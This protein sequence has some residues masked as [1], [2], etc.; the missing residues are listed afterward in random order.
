MTRHNKMLLSFLL[1]F[2]LSFQGLLPIFAQEAFGEG[3]SLTENPM[4]SSLTLE[5]DELEEGL[6]FTENSTEESSLALE[7][8]EALPKE[9]DEL[10]DE[11]IALDENTPLGKTGFFSASLAVTNLFESL[12]EKVLN[13]SSGDT[14]TLEPGEY[15]FTENLVVDKPLTFVSEGDVTFKRSP[16]LTGEMISITPIG[17]LTLNKGDGEFVFD[18]EGRAVNTSAYF[19][20]AEGN[21]EI[22]GAIFQN[23][24]AR[25]GSRYA[26][27]K[28][29]GA[30]LVFNQGKIHSNDYS[31]ANTAYSSGGIFLERG[32]SME[33]NGGEISANQASNYLIH[34]SMLWSDSPGAGAIYVHS[35]ASFVMNAGLIKSNK[36]WAGG[37]LIG[38]SS[39]YTYKR[40]ATTESSLIESPLATAVFNGGTIEG[41]EAVGGA[42]SG[43]GNVDITL[44]EASSVLIQ[45]NHS[46][47]GGG[48]FI[49]DWAV[50]G[51]GL[52][53]EIAKLPIE[54]WSR[55]YQGRFFMAGG[56][57]INNTAINCG[58]G[59][60]VSTNGAQIVGGEILNNRAG[61]QGG[62]IYVTTVPYT[63]KLENVYI[64]SNSA[65]YGTTT[66]IDGIPLYN[67]SGGGV[68]FCPTGSA[69]FH[70]ENGAALVDNTAAR[71]GDDFWSSRKVQKQGQS[72][73]V[74]L[75]DRLLGGTKALYYTDKRGARYTE[76]SGEAPQ[77]I[78]EV[79]TDLS[80]KS[81][82]DEGKAITKALSTLHIIGNRASKGGG[83][84]S[85]GNIIFG[86]EGPLKNIRLKKVWAEG[87][88][89]EAVT[90]ELRA[91][92]NGLDYLIEAVQLDASNGF[93]ATIKD[94]PQTIGAHPLEEVVY[95]KELQNANYSATI[96]P[97][98]EST[99]HD[100]SLNLSLNRPEFS[101]YENIHAVYE[102][103]T[104]IAIKLHRAGKEPIIK[105]MSMDKSTFTWQGR[106]N[107]EGL[108]VGSERVE[109]DYY[110]APDGSLISQHLNSYDVYLEETEDKVIIRLPKIYPDNV[111]APDVP[112]GDEKVI[113]ASYQVLRDGGENANQTF[114]FTVT[115][116][117]KA[118]FLDVKKLWQ[119]ISPS[120]APEVKVYL[121]KN[122]EKT[123][124]FLLLNQA[125]NWQGRFENL[126]IR[127]NGSHEDNQYSVKEDGEEN[128]KITLANVAYQVT[129]NG[130][131]V[132]N[133]RE[134]VPLIPSTT[135]LKVKK[136]WRGVDGLENL[137]PVKVYLY[138]NGE[139][140]DKFILLTKENNWQGEFTNLA[141]VDELT[142]PIVNR[143]SVD[144]EAIVGFVKV[145]S[146]SAKGYTI[147]NSVPPG[148]GSYNPPPKPPNPPT[149][150]EPP[151]PPSPPPFI[152]NEPIPPSPP[153]TPEKPSMPNKPKPKKPQP[154]KPLPKTGIN[155]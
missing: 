125:N 118:T 19:I 86:K 51:I 151:K 34:G 100:Y 109:L 88:T 13:A 146:G 79:S 119:G 52:D 57:V 74:T 105:M 132:T 14:I 148:G 5:E 62:G 122:G 65:N 102:E 144:E 60:N 107:F 10:D 7:R 26:P 110:T 113:K 116:E 154:K 85:N 92:V 49:S 69:T 112:T 91:N 90:L 23:A 50:D 44:P 31:G 111:E 81:V 147:E 8:A 39:P 129:Y 78:K 76:G 29:I 103:S 17:A 145:V 72:F 40:N 99:T 153:L 150:P 108:V 54:T 94:L 89:P 56:K 87:T 53:K 4:E 58:G 121:Y 133:T 117:K 101:A 136:V 27:I 155:R 32:A 70:V 143:Y 18:G 80:L 106:V 93:K 98:S 43:H 152:P 97:I 142:S 124:H 95:V 45:N 2:L 128:L 77:S 48:I 114:E 84:G 15:L 64:D 1:I 9:G 24:K 75:A 61:D 6:V 149:P 138:K 36:G 127:D 30:R 41:N 123:E 63:L 11:T 115:N 82:V 35:G 130:G 59:I 37:V 22:N 139:K 68:W 55:H 47:Q 28:V 104:D 16:S 131:T 141:S 135:K 134:W 38:D 25:G 83:I 12:K 137:P 73:S 67:G 126:P 42:I 66:I 96:S 71:E 46:Y 21:L 140:T 20:K 33:M 120:Q 3:L